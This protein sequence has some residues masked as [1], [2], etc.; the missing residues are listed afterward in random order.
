MKLRWTR[1]ALADLG[2]VCD[3]IAEDKPAVAEA[4]AAAV[5]NKVERL[6]EFPL[7]GRI[8]ALEDTREFVVHKNSLVTYRV[9][10]DEVQVLP[11]WHLARNLPRGGGR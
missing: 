4:F 7:L 3:R 8:G 5:F 2:R 11:V 6:R 9:R 1:R 10:A